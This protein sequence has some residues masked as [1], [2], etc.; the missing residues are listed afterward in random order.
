MKRYLLLFLLACSLQGFSQSPFL[1][2][3]L[4]NVI[5]GNSGSISSLAGSKGTAIVFINNNCPFVKAYEAR[6]GDLMSSYKSKGIAFVFVNPSV[7]RNGEKD[8]EAAMK[9]YFNNLNWNVPYLADPDQMLTQQLGATRLPEVFVLNSGGQLVYSGALD[10]NP[11]DESSANQ[12][13]LKAVLNSVISGQ[14]PSKNHMALG[15]RIKKF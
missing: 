2:T 10:N 3:S 9:K 5:S 14:K 4:K 15:C 13:Y 8:S 1:Q 6:I 11:Q 12:H 7:K